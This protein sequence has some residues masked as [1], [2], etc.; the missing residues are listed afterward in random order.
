MQSILKGRSV[1]CRKPKSESECKYECCHY[2][3]KWRYGDGE[4]RTEFPGLCH[5][6]NFSASLNHFREQC[7]SCKVGCESRK[8]SGSVC[9]G[10]CHQKHFSRCL[11][12][13]GNGW[14]Y[15]SHDDQRNGKSEKL[16]EDSVECNE[17]SHR[18]SWGDKSEAH[19]KGNRD[20]NLAEKSDL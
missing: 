8:H 4:I 14:C 6:L 1:K 7:R 9:D 11:S 19:A 16:A 10:H 18:P 2:I 15:Q 17:Y 20:Q 5:F 3:H 13:V 12:Y